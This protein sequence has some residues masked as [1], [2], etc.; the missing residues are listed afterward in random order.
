M[1]TYRSYSPELTARLERKLVRKID[2]RIMPLVVTIYIFSYLDRNS[3]TQARLY[4]L[5]RDTHTTGSIYNTAIAIFSAGYVAMQLPSTVL[6]TKLRPSIYLP[7][8]IIVWAIVSGSTAATTNPAGLLFVRFLL[9]IVEAP[10]YPGAVYFL[11]CWY[12][13]KELGIRMAFLICGLLLSNAFAGL[14]SAGILEGMKTVGHLAPW[15]WLFILEGL[16]TLLLA[17]IALIFLPDYPG[18]TK[19]LSEEERVVAQGRLAQ[20]A[21]SEEVLDEETVSMGKGINLAMRD[22]R[23]W[24]FA[25]LQMSAAASISYSHFFPTLIQELGFKSNVTTLLLTSP[26]YVFAFVWALSLAYNADRRQTR[27][28]HAAISMVI[29]IVGTVLLIAVPVKYR[30]PRYAFTFLVAAGSFGVYSTTYT[31]L[32]STII[33]PPVKRAAAIGIANTI[34]NAAALYASYF[35]LDKYSPSFRVSWSCSLAFMVLGLICI[36]S[37]RLVLQRGNR[38]FDQLVV[39]VD[40]NDHVAVARLDDDSTRAIRNGFRYII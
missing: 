31:W 30:W 5:E 27:S 39:D 20:D 16:A 35:W 18:N 34:S 28:P 14:I 21:A 13:K 2:K 32:S 17:A 1:I 12:T 38:R 24:L 10:F 11:S 6:M 37:L 33:R 36:G 25:G 3:I 4:G 29:S 22:Y 40:P 8:T 9:G 7:T 26:P 15:R 23:T 19:W